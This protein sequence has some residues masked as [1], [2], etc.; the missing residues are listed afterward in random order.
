ME[1]SANF[2]G[3]VGRQSSSVVGRNRRHSAALPPDRLARGELVAELLRGGDDQ[4]A[5]LNDRGAAGL[6]GAVASCA[7]Q[8]D[9]LDNPIGLLRD[10]GRLP[11]QRESGGHLGVDRIALAAPAAGVRVR[12]VDLEDPNAV[13]AQV[14]HERSGV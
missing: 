13:L 7:Q 12:L 6:H 4:P 2:A 14:A 5:E 3:C 1:R 10:R 8:P 11:R 9:R